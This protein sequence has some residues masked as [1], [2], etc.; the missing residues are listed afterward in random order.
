MN[1]AQKEALINAYLDLIGSF[2]ET[3][4]R[5]HDWAG[6]LRSINEI[7]IAFK[8]VLEENDCNTSFFEDVIKGNVYNKIELGDDSYHLSANI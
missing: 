4:G 2:E 3:Y 1:K 7:S 5:P 8:S 6:H